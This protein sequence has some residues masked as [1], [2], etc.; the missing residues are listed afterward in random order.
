MAD[1]SSSVSDMAAQLKV[2]EGCWAEWE[3]ADGDGRERREVGLDGN[4]P[5]V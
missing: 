1:M 5:L 2:E 3:A 4:T